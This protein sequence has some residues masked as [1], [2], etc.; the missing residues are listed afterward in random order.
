V[1]PA[2][3]EDVNDCDILPVEPAY[4]HDQRIYPVELRLVGEYGLSRVF[5]VELQFPLRSVTTTVEYHTPDGEH[6]EPVDPELHHRNETVFGPSDPW[7]LL[8]MGD[9]FSGFWLAARPGIS[10]PLGST[11][12]DPFELGDSGLRHQH[13]QLGTGT[14][15]PVL[16]LEASK[17]FG[18]M[19]LDLFAQ[20]TASLYENSHG[21]R[22]PVRVYAGTRVGTEFL[23]KTFGALGLDV[24][25]DGADRW[26]GAIRQDGNLG[27]SEILAALALSHSF[28]TLEL[29][30]TLRAPL[31]RHIV[32]GNEA[33]GTMSAPLA[34]TFTVAQSFDTGP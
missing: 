25:H 33:P 24:L 17:I 10:I 22:G 3:C 6:Y 34:V 9:L 30:L 27:R 4:D 18:E 23:A 12:E 7:L 2:G 5:G 15:D 11:E 14:F 28:D 21:Y 31:Y 20:G 19:R 26:D 13:I 29:G 32:V 1:H 16:V 8:R